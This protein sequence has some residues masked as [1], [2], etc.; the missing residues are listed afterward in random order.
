M[1]SLMSM[2]WALIYDKTMLL[3]PCILSPRP[4]DPP[5]QHGGLHAARD[6]HRSVLPQ[7]D[8]GQSLQ[9]KARVHKDRNHRLQPTKQVRQVAPGVA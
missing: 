2:L 4:K 7:R 8:D 3:L 9:R 1:H 5:A 6:V